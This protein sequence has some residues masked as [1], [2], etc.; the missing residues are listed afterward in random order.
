MAFTGRHNTGSPHVFGG[1]WTT[2]E[3]EGLSEY[4]RNYTKA[5]KYKPTPERPF[6]KTFIDAFAG[7]SYRL[8]TQDSVD[9]P[10]QDELF[11]ELAAAGPQR[12]LEELCSLG[13]RGSI[14]PFEKYILLRKIAS[15]VNSWHC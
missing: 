3:A 9:S 8:P 14:P 2:Q 15:D 11:P 6:R 12:L 5:L 4:L 1:E 7:T 10:T 13:S